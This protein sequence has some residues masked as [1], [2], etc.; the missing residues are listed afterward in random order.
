R[1]FR[2]AD[3]DH[4]LFLS[5]HLSIVD[6]VSVYQIFPFELAALYR[7]YSSGQPNPLPDLNVQFGDYAHWQR[8]WLQSGEAA[9]QVAYWRKQMAGPIPV[10]NWPVD[11]ARPAHETFSGVIKTFVVRRELVEALEALC[12]QDGVTLFMGLLAGLVSLLH[13]YTQ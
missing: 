5:A 13:L 3:L 1:M 8:E 11:R 9:R 2:T 7:A 10:L 4:S 6:G 12:R